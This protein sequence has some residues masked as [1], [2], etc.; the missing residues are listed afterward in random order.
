[1]KFDHAIIYVD[2]V[3]KATEEIKRIITIRLDA[4]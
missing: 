1:M 3:V 2:D 4:K